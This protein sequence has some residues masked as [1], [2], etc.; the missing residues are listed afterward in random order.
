MIYLGC[1]VGIYRSSNHQSVY[2]LLTL[3]PKTSLPL[4]LL[5]D[6]EFVTNACNAATCPF[7]QISGV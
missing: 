4:P 6:Y 7:S 1:Q 5:I 2:K 3:D